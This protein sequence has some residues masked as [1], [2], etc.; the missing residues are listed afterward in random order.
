MR[1]EIEERERAQC[2]RVPN[3]RRQL[4][5]SLVNGTCP[6]LAS[7]QVQPDVEYGRAAIALLEG[8]F[9]RLHQPSEDERERLEPVDW[10]FEIERLLESLFGHR[11]HKWQRG[12][13]RRDA[14]PPR[15]G[16]AKPRRDIIGWQGREFAKGAK[17]PVAEGGQQIVRIVRVV[18]VRTDDAE[19]CQRKRREQRGLG[20][21]LD[22]GEAGAVVDEQAGGG[23]GAGDRNADA[24]AAISGG[25]TDRRGDLAT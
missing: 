10:P 12:F 25:G 6:V 13:P 11:R 8:P 22:Y 7:D 21:R 1:L 19:K 3:R 23:A 15:A 14:L 17:T 20:S 9:E 18:R 24:Q 4:Q 5:R 16:V 2:P